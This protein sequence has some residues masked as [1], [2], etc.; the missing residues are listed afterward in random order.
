M[1]RQE[2]HGGIKIAFLDGPLQL[3]NAWPVFLFS[4]ITPFQGSFA[5]FALNMTVISR[6]FWPG[7]SFHPLEIGLLYGMMNVVGACAKL[8]WGRLADKHS[9]KKLLAFFM[10]WF[11]TMFALLGFIPE[12]MGNLSFYAFLSIALLRETFT[13]ELPTCLSYIDDAVDEGKRSRYYGATSLVQSLVTI[14]VYILVTAVFARHWRLYFWIVGLAGIFG[15]AMIA[16]NAKEPKRGAEKQELKSV[17]RLEGLTYRYDL[18]R[19]AVK[20]TILTRTNILILV[21][22]IFTQLVWGIPTFLIIGFVQSPPY[23]I[24][25]FSMSLFFVLFGIPGVM[26]ASTVLAR[27]SDKKARESVKNR[28]YIIFFSISFFCFSCI[29]V[30][31]IPLDQFSP[32]EGGNF[33]SIMGHGTYWIAGLVILLAEMFGTSY[34]VNQRPLLQKINLPEAQGAISAVNLFLEVLANGIGIIM[35][36]SLLTVTGNNYAA[37][38]LFLVSIATPGI[39]MWLLCG[40]WIEGDLA[41]VSELLK[42]RAEEIKSPT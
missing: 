21:E 30:F 26:I 19:E 22:G 5:W 16:I 7:D 15:S 8:V 17:L 9:R 37:T 10:A 14:T 11:S 20:A 28:I 39:I 29:S 24:T 40:R 42:K 34:N 33:F 2:R 6:L 25:P 12:G 13:A 31:I 18:T 38:V 23:N 36:G 3:R 4:V 41:R 35:A 27:Y 32:E 1:E